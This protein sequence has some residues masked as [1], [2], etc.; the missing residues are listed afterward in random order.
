MNISAPD[1]EPEKWN[2]K[3]ND[4][5]Y[6]SLLSLHS[7]II[8]GVVKFDFPDR[9][10]IVDT[11]MFPVERTKTAVIRIAKDI[12]EGTSDE[13]LARKYGVSPEDVKAIKDPALALYKDERYGRYANCYAYAMDDSDRYNFNGASPGDRAALNTGRLPEDSV[14]DYA[15]FKQS[16]IKGIEADGAI[17]A[18]KNADSISGYYKVAVFTKQQAPDESKDQGEFDMHFIR[19]DK[20]GWSH[21]PGA[22]PVTDKDYKGN[23]ITDPEKA[24]IGYDFIGYALVPEG[25]LD[26]GGS[27]LEPKSK[28]KSIEIAPDVVRAGLWQ[29]RDLAAFAND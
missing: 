20:N 4:E 28:P 29:K 2:S 7:K 16:I 25:G 18:G 15:S 13:T 22:L 17:F 11:K 27:A 1:Y 24:D 14:K 9:D 3:V 12:E 8:Q 21:K 10:P 6:V 5:D 26:V 19:Q 23:K